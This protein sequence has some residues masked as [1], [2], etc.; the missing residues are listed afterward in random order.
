MK[1]DEFKFAELIK[2]EMEKGH[3]LYEVEGVKVIDSTAK[4]ITGVAFGNCFN[5]GILIN[6]DRLIQMG[7]DHNEIIAVVGHEAGHVK[8]HFN[9]KYQ[10]RS[11]DTEIE[12][13]DYSADL[14][15]RKV[16]TSML[17]KLFH[18]TKCTE[19]WARLQHQLIN[20]V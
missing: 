1:V 5:A 9:D 11:L 15:G 12:A 13:D 2:S 8:L 7:L 17:A 18:H 10:G 4:E 19:V 20:L 3:V 14:V 16:V 6:M